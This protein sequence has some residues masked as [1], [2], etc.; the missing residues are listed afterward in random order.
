MKT[1]NIPRQLLFYILTTLGVSLLTC[2]VFY[3][4]MTRSFKD[5]STLT[6]QTMTKLDQ[7][8][9]LLGQLSDVQTSV[10]QIL[11]LKD[12]D[13]LE[14][15]LKALDLKQK[16]TEAR[17]QAA[18][19][20]ASKIKAGFNQLEAAD[21][22][23]VNHLLKGDFGAANETL[24]T[25]SNPLSD[26]VRLEVDKYY[27][28]VDASAK[29]ELASQQAT[30][31]THLLERF[32]LLGVVLAAT[33]VYGWRMRSRITTE[34]RAISL[35]LADTGRAV[36]GSSAQVAETSQSVS[37]G[38]HHQAAS[39]EESSASLEGISSM[40]GRNAQTAQNAK[41]LASQ[42][43][44]AAD[45]GSADMQAMTAAMNAI[46]T[47]SDN[48]SKII[49][50]ID[51]IAF[52]TNILALNA[53]VEAARAGEAGMGFAVVAEEVRNLAH[54][55]AQAARETAERIEDSIQ[56]SAQGAR[57]CGQVGSS[58]QEIVLKAREV[59]ELVAEIASASTEQ[60]QGIAQ[61]NTAVSE[62]DKVT[63]SN[64][65]SAE[66][67]AA[68]G[69]DLRAQAGALKTAVEDLERLV[70]GTSDP[71][72]HPSHA[73]APG[74]PKAGQ[75]VRVPSAHRSK[76]RTNGAATSAACKPSNR[77]VIPLDQDFRDM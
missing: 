17:I 75:A 28:A 43:R 39:L 47:S 41:Q 45:R 15:A 60:S 66:K 38:A 13:E 72:P 30:T 10:Q 44:I 46:K 27:Q 64:A 56:K 32:S 19:E 9:A 58:L 69:A 71:K 1:T 25:T 33:V 20:A 6:A 74:E 4:M 61:V 49:K 53:A 57:I 42:T 70:G 26:A 65:V 2:A 18:G 16:S 22:A 77:E 5:N 31:R 54:R 67:S 76:V 34:L 48:I 73:P 63:Q 37:E 23:V 11:R 51:E 55:S 7:T 3:V 14:S 24:L 12:P 8:R 29:A 59:D 40:P 50:T 68:A 62:M 36:A 21:K 35:T 52:Q